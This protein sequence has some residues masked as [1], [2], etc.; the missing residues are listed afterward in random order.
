MVNEPLSGLCSLCRKRPMA[1][2]ALCEPCAEEHD[3]P[4]GAKLE[5]LLAWKA[6]GGERDRSIKLT[7]TKH[8]P[9]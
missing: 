5:A 1:H 8:D 4:R 6:T 3:Y 9:W 7:K 2:M